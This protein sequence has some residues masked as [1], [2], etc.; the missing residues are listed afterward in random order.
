MRA[1]CN[2]P[3]RAWKKCPFSNMKIL[4]DNGAPKPISRS[5]LGHEVTFARDIGW[6][7]LENGDLIKQA[8]IAGFQLLLS[9]HKN[10]R[11]QQNLSNRKIALVVLGQQQ[12]PIVR[13][14]LEHIIKAVNAATRQIL[15]SEVEI[16]TDTSN[17]WPLRPQPLVHPSA[18]CDVKCTS[19]PIAPPI[20]VASTRCTIIWCSGSLLIASKNTM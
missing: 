13:L 3:V 14:H 6:H 16:S 1:V 2:L 8:E 9:T 5:L 10:I 7:Q 12:W 4:F 19:I 17:S 20:R 11:Y 18:W 15:R